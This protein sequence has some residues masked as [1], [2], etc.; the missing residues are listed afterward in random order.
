MAKDMKLVIDPELLLIC[1]VAG[2]PAGFALTLP[3]VNQAQKKVRDGK[4]LP[5]GIFKLL[6]P[7][8]YPT[9]GDTVEI[10]VPVAGG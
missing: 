4:L 1:E 10:L 7:A 9:D 8:S 6:S 3:D 2:K 5:F